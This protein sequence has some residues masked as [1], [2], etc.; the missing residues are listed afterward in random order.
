[1]L[2]IGTM[3]SLTRVGFAARGIIYFLIGYLALR[4]G[5]T[6]DGSGILD[7][8]NSGAGKLLLGLMAL[9]LLAYGL[10]RLSEAAIDS[11]GHGADAKGMGVRAGGA[12][13]G[14]IHLGLGF[15]AASLAFGGG[16]GGSSGG[17]TQEGAATALSFP[18]GQVALTLVAAGLV[19]TAFVQF[20]K[21]F[22]AGF[23]KHLDPQAARKSWV[24]AIGRAGY[25]ARG[26]VFLI[27]GWF[28][29][30]SAQ[31]SNAAEAGDMGTALASLPSTLQ[32]IVAAGL[33]L[34]GLFSMVE[35]IYRR[36]TDPHV[37]ERLGST[38]RRATSGR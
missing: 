2:N 22:R 16:R 34:F 7:Y 25:A 4:T 17:G 8:L 30:R 19:V 37:L 9:G 23:L 26:V 5:R 28:L 38:A 15:Y 18:G 13:S 10:W 6:E 31:Q 36:I 14:L 32:L 35:A 29:W 33:L 11:E 12:I 3:E 1:M 20:M 24:K 21:A 27:M